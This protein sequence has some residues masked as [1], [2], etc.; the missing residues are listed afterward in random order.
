VVSVS[1][2]LSSTK[3]TASVLNFREGRWYSYEDDEQVVQ[4]GVESPSKNAYMLFYYRVDSLT[5]K[6]NTTS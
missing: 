1:S 5:Y 6:Y 3:F 2:F 4:K